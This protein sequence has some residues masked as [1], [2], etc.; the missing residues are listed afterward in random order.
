MFESLPIYFNVRVITAG[1]YT[2]IIICIWLWLII[3][4]KTVQSIVYCTVY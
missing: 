4:F 2:D 3:T 1:W